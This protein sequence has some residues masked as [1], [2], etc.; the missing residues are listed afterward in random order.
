MHAHHARRLGRHR[1]LFLHGAP[2]RFLQQRA[3][4]RQ[5]LDGSVAPLLDNLGGRRSAEDGI[6]L[7]AGADHQIGQRRL[8]AHVLHGEDGDGLA[9]HVEHAAQL[10]ARRQ[11]AGEVDGDHGIAGE[12]LFGRFHRHVGDHAAVDEQAAVDLPRI[13]H[14]GNGHGRAHGRGQR[15]A[16]QHH[17]LAA[18][19][20]GGDSRKRDGQT[21]EIGHGHVGKQLSD[22]LEHTRASDEPQRPRHFVVNVGVDFRPDHADVARSFVGQIEIIAAARR[23]Q[24]AEIDVHDNPLQLLGRS[25]AGIETADD[26]PHAGADDAGDANAFLF[27]FPKH[28][29]VGV[30]LDAAAGQRQDHVRF[31]FRAGRHRAERQRRQQPPPYFLHASAPPRGIMVHHSSPFLR[32]IRL[33][34]SGFVSTDRLET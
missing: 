34:G 18:D 25:A 10:L 3:D 4:L 17:F 15:A 16:A 1:L 20:I 12:Q 9:D 33:P 6:L 31:V 8:A 28:A 13:E 5:S 2:R 26:G 7:H 23:N 29:D 24:L 14:A 19:Q 27:Q 21:A 30:P 11:L 32:K 22:V